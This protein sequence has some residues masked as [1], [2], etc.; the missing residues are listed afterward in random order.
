MIPESWIMPVA[1]GLPVLEV[2]AA[3]GLLMDIRGSL[4][5]ITALLVLFMGILGYGVWM[6]LDIDCG[7]F[8]PEDPEADAYNGLRPALYRDI[9]MMAGVCY[10]Y[11][12]R[13]HRS[14][15]PIRLKAIFKNKSGEEN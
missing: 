6:G 15:S 1:V 9:V 10:L 13:F 11:F 2:L 4:T 3:L 14:V 5:V 8:G 7:C 12:W